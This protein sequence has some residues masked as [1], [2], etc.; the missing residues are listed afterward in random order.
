MY[1]IAQRLLKFHYIFIFWSRV[2]QESLLFYCPRKL[3]FHLANI[4]FCP[5]SESMMFRCVFPT[6]TF[7]YESISSKQISIF[8]TNKIYICINIYGWS[9]IDLLLVHAWSSIFYKF[10]SIPL[11]RQVRAANRFPLWIIEKRPFPAIKWTCRWTLEMEMKASS[12]RADSAIFSKISFLD[13][14]LF[15]NN[16]RLVHIRVKNVRQVRIIRIIFHWRDNWSQAIVSVLIIFPL[17]RFNVAIPCYKSDLERG[18][19]VVFKSANMAEDFGPAE[20]TSTSYNPPM[21]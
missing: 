2:D 12:V 18:E 19:G 6:I 16:N 17:L 11:R 8:L 15:S 10:Y 9:T 5:T 1:K 21:I 14:S 3:S 4:N 7:C 13:T 20:I